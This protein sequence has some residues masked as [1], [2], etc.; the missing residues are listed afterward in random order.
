MITSFACKKTEAVFRGQRGDRK[1]DSFLRVVE[2]KFKM[3]HAAAKL[4]DLKV[5]PN[6]RLEKL[7]GDRK[8]QLSIRINV[9]WRVCFEWKDGHARNVEICNYH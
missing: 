1:W 6:N 8:S 4:S 9:Q 2:R 3:V 5:P 7:E